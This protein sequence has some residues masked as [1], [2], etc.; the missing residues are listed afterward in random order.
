SLVFNCTIS[1]NTSDDNGGGISCWSTQHSFFNCLVANNTSR[2]GAGIF[3]FCV[4]PYLTFMNCTVV[5][6][7][8]SHQGG[9]YLGSKIADPVMTNCIL[10]NNIPEE[11]AGI[12]P[13]II[14]S[15]IMGGFPGTG[16]IDED[17]LFTTGIYGHYYLSQTASGQTEDS[18]CIDSGSDL[19]EFICASTLPDPVC[20][21]EM[22]TRTDQTGDAG[23]VD[24][25]FHYPVEMPSCDNTGDV[26]CNGIITAGDGQMAFMIALG[27]LTPDYL[28]ACAAD[29]NATGDVTAGDAQA[30]F[31]AALGIGT[32]ADG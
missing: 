29:C 12:P 27:L 24:M 31:L 8:A 20:L 28:E 19:S 6:N 5:G 3:G 25:G 10:W 22:T 16:N 11:T 7:T 14:F 13:Q 21:D 2:Y 17:P 1:G 23:L 30:I 18:P 32:C 15:D 9:G 26:D 4:S